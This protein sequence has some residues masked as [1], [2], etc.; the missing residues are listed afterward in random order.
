MVG[1]DCSGRKEGKGPHS[2]QPSGHRTVDS[3]EKTFFFFI[4]SGLL[5]ICEIAALKNPCQNE[6]IVE[7]GEKELFGRP[8]IVP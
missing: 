5:N 4:N 8:K 1:L 6:S 2:S 3:L 7:L